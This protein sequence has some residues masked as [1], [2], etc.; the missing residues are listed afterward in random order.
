MVI[1]GVGEDEVEIID[2]ANLGAGW[3]RRAPLPQARR[4]TNSVLTPD[5]AVITIGGNLEENYISPQKEALR[6]D[7]AADTWTP[8]AAQAEERGYH[9]TALLLP[10]GRI[11]SAGDDGP[12]GLGGQSDEIEVF[13][14]PYLFKGARPQITSAPSAVPYGSSFGVGTPGRRRRQGGP[15]GAGRD[16]PRQRHAPA[17]GAAGH[18]ADG[19]R[20]AADG[21]GEHVDRAA[22]PLHAVPGRTRRASP[23]WR[24]SSTWRP[25]LPPRRRTRPRCRPRA[26]A[27][28]R[29]LPARPLR[30][31]R[32]RLAL[33]PGRDR[34]GSARAAV[35]LARGLREPDPA[36]S[37]TRR[38]CARPTRAAGRCGV[39]A[40]AVVPGPALQA[41]TYRA[42]LRVRNGGVRLSA[43]ATG[44]TITLALTATPGTQRWRRVTDTVRLG[45]AGPVRVRLRVA[46]GGA[47]VDDLVLSRQR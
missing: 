37:R 47:I 27:A 29:P 8:L 40:G 12:S 2:A 22:G 41:G 34:P 39:G 23:R 43:T 4:N 13:S 18:D 44:R 36:A 11:V 35:L 15:G 3:A 21:A 14:P 24:A 26:R 42:I 46:R 45:T 30:A 16:H 6:Y 33:T 25:R 9:S 17:A 10:D 32:R 1:G 5:G 28:G 19:R 31:G 38:G 20:P 7:P